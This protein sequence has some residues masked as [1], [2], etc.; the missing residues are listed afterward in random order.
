MK[1]MMLAAA[2]LA[3]AMGVNPASTLAA[4]PG[5]GTGNATPQTADQRSTDRSADPRYEWHYYYGKSG[6]VEG[7]WVLVR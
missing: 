7:H 6:Q 5:A 3:L 1:T 2:A 4:D